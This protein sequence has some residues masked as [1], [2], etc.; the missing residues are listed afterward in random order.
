MKKAILH[1]YATLQNAYNQ[2]PDY[3]QVFTSFDDAQRAGNDM[4]CN[5]EC[6]AYDVYI[7]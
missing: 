2:K 6:A 4:F 7:I 5:Q 1:T 3:L